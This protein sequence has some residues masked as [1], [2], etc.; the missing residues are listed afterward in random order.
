M[1][2]G[3]SAGLG[4][5]GGEAESNGRETEASIS[6]TKAQDMVRYIAES[7]I[8]RCEQSPCLHR[9]GL[10]FGHTCLPCLV[11][12]TLPGNQAPSQAL[13]TSY[14]AQ[15]PFRAV[16]VKPT[17]LRCTNTVR[18]HKPHAATGAMPTS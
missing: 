1:V 14:R 5:N 10:C 18:R 9:P 17:C 16:V 4:R 6:K 11:S 3:G 12:S 15:T 13:C 2:L 7:N 8:V